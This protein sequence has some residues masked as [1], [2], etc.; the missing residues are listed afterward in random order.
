MEIYF[1]RKVFFSIA[2]KGAIN[3]HMSFLPYNRGK[4]PNVWPIIEGTP[5]G[6]CMHY[7]DSGIDTGK[8]IARKEVPVEMIDTGKTLYNK[9]L[10]AF[11]ELFIETW[12]KLKND[13]IVSVEQEDQNT[14]YHTSKDFE[15]LG[16]IFL[17]KE[18]KA[19]ELINILRSKTF[20]PHDSS[21]FMFNGKKFFYISQSQRRR[22]NYGNNAAF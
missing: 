21:F 12:P 2:P 16:E 19:L 9:Q 20:E 3:F 11:E 17:D 4:N 10:N 5:A 8:I 13:E 15:S 7:I 1:A 14:T 18:Y 22:V 6:V